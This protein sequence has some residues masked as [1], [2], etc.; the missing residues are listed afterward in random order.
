M[1]SFGAYIGRLRGRRTKKEVAG[2]AGFS[3][4]YLRLIEENDKIPSIGILIRLAG[5][6]E[7]DE[8]EVLFKALRQKAPDRAKKYFLTS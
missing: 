4:E 1:E 7:A 6:L 5:A 3:A 8:K 2:R